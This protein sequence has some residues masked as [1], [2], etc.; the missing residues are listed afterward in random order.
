MID[1]EGRTTNFSYDT[2]DRLTSLADVNG[3]FGFG[4]DGLSRRTSLTRSNGVNTNYSYDSLSRLLS[5]THQLSGSTI[6]G[7]SYTPDSVGNR[8][9]KTDLRTQ[10]ATS[11][12]YDADLSAPQRHAGRESAHHHGKLHLRSR[13]Q[14]A[15][16]PHRAKLSLQLLERADQP[17]QVPGPVTTV[18]NYD[19]NGNLTSKTG[20]GST[21]TYTWDFEN[22]LSSATVNGVTTNFKYD[23][24]GRRVYK[25]SSGVN[26]VYVYDGDNLIEELNLSGVEI[27]HYTQGPGIDEPLAELRSGTTNFYQAD[28]LGSITSLTNA[29]GAMANTYTYDSFGNLTASSGSVTNPFQFT[30]RDFDSETGLY[31][32][33]AR[34]FDPSVGSFISEDPEW[35]LGG[36]N[37]YSYVSA[38][39]INLVDPY[40]LSALS[41]PQM[42]AMAAEN[43][44]SGQSDE[45][46]IC[47]AFKE[48]TFDP[49]AMQT[50]GQTARGLLGV[51]LG[52]AADVGTDYEDLSDPATNIATGSEYLNIRIRRRHGNVSLGLAGYG[53]GRRYARSLLLCEKCLEQHPQMPPGCKTAACLDPLHAPPQ[54]PRHR[55]PHTKRRKQ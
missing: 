50:G 12:G 5:V 34:Y 20:G 38:N 29:A 11:F 18:Y 55:A 51:T 46:I 21:A 7:A 35:F 36:L 1:P 40:G 32:Y 54:K 16:F 17:T 31:Y 28:G 49:D 23:P 30:A 43:N 22:R 19:A 3:T 4:Y 15:D 27:A 45:L 6:D 44:R 26:H 52:A 33:R 37:A 14:P 13:R 39:P 42:A 2:L 24:F 9:S 41:Y 47:M 53:T 10:L 8:T 25:S 48:S